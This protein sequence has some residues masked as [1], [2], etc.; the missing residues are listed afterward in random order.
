MGP[1]HLYLYFRG[2]FNAAFYLINILQPISNTL[3]L[4]KLTVHMTLPRTLLKE[5]SDLVGLGWTLESIYLEHS[6][7]IG[8]FMSR[9]L[10]NVD[11]RMPSFNIF[12]LLKIAYIF[13]D[14]ECHP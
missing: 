5:D 7:L 8:T 9:N 1:G 6:S 3:V 12:I 13:G 14:I 4:F 2:D 11:I 10:S